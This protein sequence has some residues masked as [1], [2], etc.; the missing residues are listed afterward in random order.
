MHHT[1]QILD[2]IQN[3]HA[4][5]LEIMKD[6]NNNSSPSSADTSVQEI[7]GQ[8]TNDERPTGRI[9]HCYNDGLHVLPQNWKLPDMTFQQLIMM[10]LC[11]DQAEGIP[12]FCLL[13][14][15]HFT[16]V[17]PRAKHVLCAMRYLMGHVE[18]ADEEANC[19]EADSRMWTQAK[20]LRLY[21]MVNHHFKCRCKRECRFH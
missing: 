9:L 16:N 11:G 13:K 4:E 18:R 15:G 19:W 21:D 7:Y 3:V 20:A 6:I 10:W 1:T 5:V 17:L 8:A 12:P 14:T 2:E